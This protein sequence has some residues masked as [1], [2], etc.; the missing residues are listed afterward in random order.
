MKKLYTSFKIPI[1]YFFIWRFIS[2]LL[3]YI[4]QFVL[5]YKPSFPYAYELL[6]KYGLPQW[7]YS[8]GN[9]DGVHY[10][11]IIE[12]GY[13]GTGLIQA[14]FPLYPMVVRLVNSIIGNT[15]LSGLIVSTF[16]ALTACCLFYVSLPTRRASCTAAIPP[17]D[18]SGAA[19]SARPGPADRSG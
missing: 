9:F 18:R 1:L 12:K 8:W 7:V 19:R 6:P 2:L 17:S 11:T 13:I 4:A 10:L 5:V 14:F 3:G 15:L 16:F